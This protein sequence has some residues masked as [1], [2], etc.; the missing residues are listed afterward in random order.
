MPRIVNKSQ[1][2]I[3]CQAPVH[4]MRLL[5]PDCLLARQR[6]PK[7]E[8]TRR[9]M[10]EYQKGRKHHWR[11]ASTRPEVAEKIRQAWTPEMREDARLRGLRLAADSDWRL[12][13]GS[14][15]QKNPN[16]QDG[17][18]QLPYS[19]GWARKVKELAWERAENHCELCGLAGYDTHHI[20]FEKDNHELDNLQVLC[21]KCHKQLHADHL[22]KQKCRQG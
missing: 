7:S 4:R 18:A 6:R 3:D 15:G 17:R 14:P 9:R 20:D 10:S 21:R 22:R 1:K 11:P 5:C 2:C 12:R 16:W 13:C 8:E 19:P